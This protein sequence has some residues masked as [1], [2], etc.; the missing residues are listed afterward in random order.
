MP[1]IQPLTAQTSTRSPS[2]CERYQKA[3]SNYVNTIKDKA[4]LCE[5]YQR[6]HYQIQR[7]LSRDCEAVLFQIYNFPEIVVQLPHKAVRKPTLTCRKISNAH[8]QAL[9]QPV[10]II[11]TREDTCGIHSGTKP[12]ARAA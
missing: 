5:R 9:Y 10:H 11:L 1:G 6:E 4:V 3:A 7:C 12:S 2:L 8:A